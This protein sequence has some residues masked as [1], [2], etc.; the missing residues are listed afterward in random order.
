MRYMMLIYGTETPNGLS[1]QDAEKSMAAHWAVIQDATRKGILVGAEPLA[2]TTSA[3][4]VRTR[5]GQLS[6][7]DGPFAETKEQLAGYYILECQNLDETIEWAARIPT[8][9]RGETGC[10]E[11]RPM[12][13]LPRPV[14]EE[15]SASAAPMNG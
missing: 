14:P 6:I 11:I 13:G 10:I 8:C 7:L 2:P 15:I 5:N 9:C 3:T 1:K 4:T 12:P